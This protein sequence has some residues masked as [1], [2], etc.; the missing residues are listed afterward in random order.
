MKRRAA[1]LL[2]AFAASACKGGRAE[3]PIPALSSREVVVPE[4]SDEPLPEWCHSAYW[5]CV[6]KGQDLNCAGS[7]GDGP[8]LLGP[9]YV[10]T[11]DPYGLDDDKDGIG[12]E[13]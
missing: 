12:C 11:S 4:W 6:P 13:R 1:T 5:P 9:V 3:T 7:G 2:L 10:I 8:F